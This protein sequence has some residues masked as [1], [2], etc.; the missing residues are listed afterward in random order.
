VLH[1]SEP[2]G[3]GAPIVL[4]TPGT[5][6][7]KSRSTTPLQLSCRSDQFPPGPGFGHGR[8]LRKRAS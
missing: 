6:V 4:P 7:A 1:L 3:A 2:A 8:I 5:S